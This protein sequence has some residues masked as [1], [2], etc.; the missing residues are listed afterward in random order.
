MKYLRKH[1]IAL[2]AATACMTVG[3]AFADELSIMASGGAWQDAQRKAWFEPFSNETGAKILEQEYLGDLGKVKAM[4]E[5]GNVPIDLVTVETATV[6]Q[7]CD[8]GILER[9]DYSKIAPRDKFIQG[10]ALD[11]GVGLDAY[12]DILAYD[13]T[14][15]KEAPTSVLD[16][17]DTTKFPG[18]RAMRK[19]PAQN[20]EWALMADGVAP[21]DVYK[22]LATPEGVDR[23]F[24][25]LD[26]IK[27]DI[28]WW[29]AGAQPAQLLASKEVVMTTAWNGRIQNAI[30]NDKKPFKIIWNNQI[31]EYDMIS[32]PKGARNPELAYKYLAYISKPE[33]NAKLASYITYGPVRTD[34]ASF[35]AA[36][37][38]PKL[39]NAPDHLKGA[40]LVA[41]TE[42]WGDYGEDLVKRFNAWLA[43]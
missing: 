42:F 17:F 26:T 12:G 13:P 31:L 3:H 32:I 4:V 25:K 22:V 11:C 27:K 41:D 19:F 20:L 15:L 6:L 21:A 14:V 18:K 8:A 10:S 28:V 5:T 24:K 40:Y 34:A 1:L 29:D 38:L 36:D 2:A 37:A 30:D 7:G 39:P 35:V 16:L 43:Q 23:A 9:L 33:N